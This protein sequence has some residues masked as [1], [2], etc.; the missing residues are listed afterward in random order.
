MRTPQAE[1]SFLEYSYNPYHLEPHQVEDHLA[2]LGF[3]KRT[4]NA[5]GSVCLFTQSLCIML[6]RCCESVTDSGLTGIGL[7]SDIDTIRATGAEYDEQTGTYLRNLGP[8]M[9]LLMVA[10]SK[11]GAG[12]ELGVMNQTL[13]SNGDVRT[14]NLEYVSGLI[15]G[16]V[17]RYVKDFMQD[18]LGFKFTKSGG[19]YNVFMSPSNRFTLLLDTKKP[20]AKISTIIADTEDVFMATACFVANGFE[21]RKFDLDQ[22]DLKFGKMNHKIVGYNCW[23]EGNENSYTIENMIPNTAP[24]VDLI[25][26]QRKQ[27]LHIKEDTLETYY[28]D[29]VST[30]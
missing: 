21:P 16:D 22:A 28:R 25:F 14:N 4:S 17:D 24:D 9:R 27:Y 7:S 6:V 13:L 30:E 23:P 2:D 20:N 10:D 29:K 15:T 8:S 19:R 5:D 18:F 11:F 12:S 1:F 26:R 3:T